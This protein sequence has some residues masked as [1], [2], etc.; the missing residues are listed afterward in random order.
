MFSAF[1]SVFSSEA[2]H[3]PQI[4]YCYFLPVKVFHVQP[5]NAPAFLD[6]ADDNNKTVNNSWHLVSIFYVTGMV[7]RILHVLVT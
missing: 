7:L 2:Q 5:L 4:Y 6:N 1:F 3:F